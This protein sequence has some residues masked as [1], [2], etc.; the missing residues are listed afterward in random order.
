MSEKFLYFTF[1]NALEKPSHAKLFFVAYYILSTIKIQGSNLEK[2]QRT[3]SVLGFFE[4]ILDAS[5][6]TIKSSVLVLCT[7]K[8]VIAPLWAKAIFSYHVEYW[9]DTHYHISTYCGYHWNSF[10]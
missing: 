6:V 3:I 5:S 8:I 9:D 4:F 1:C 7:Y 2:I 10:H